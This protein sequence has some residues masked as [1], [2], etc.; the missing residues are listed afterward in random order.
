M[1]LD[2]VIVFVGGPDA[3][4]GMFPGCILD[5]GRRHVGQGT[6]NRRVFFARTFVE[7][8][9]IDEPEQAQ[10]SG[11]GFAAR[12]GPG[13]ACPFGVVLRGRVPATDRARFVPYH[14]PDGGPSLLVLT[15]ARAEPEL[16]FVAVWEAGAPSLHH[17]RL[18]AHPCGAQGIRRVT[19]RS[20]VLPDL[21][22]A[23]PRD[24][25]FEAGKARLLLEV[26]GLAEPWIIGG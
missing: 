26:D 16:P 7:L 25:A 20:P 19:F 2:H 9:W 13:A 5:P 23:M 11:L 24:V 6:R 21:G 22:S 3:T 8:L 17:A 14:V 15:A 1:E 18:P 4:D 12:C 10:R